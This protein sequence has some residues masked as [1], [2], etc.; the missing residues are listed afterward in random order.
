MKRLVKL[1]THRTGFWRLA[2]RLW[3]KPI[4]AVFAFH[5]VTDHATAPDHLLGYDRGLD[6][7]EFLGQLDAIGSYFSVITLEQYEKI[8]TGRKVPRQHSA[9]LTFDD[10]DSEFLQQILPTLRERNW[11]AVVFT[12][13]NFV[14]GNEFFWHV[15]V[16]HIFL[17]LTIEDRERMRQLSDLPESIST[18]LQQADISTRDGRASLSRKIVTAL[19]MCDDN[20]IL[21][22]VDRLRACCPEMTQPDIHCMNWDEHRELLANSISVQS[23]TSS[24]RRL[25][26]LTRE[27]VS[28][29]L[30]DSKE[31]LQRKLN[32]PVTSICY[33]QGS[34]DSF[35]VQESRKAGYTLGFTTH[36]GTSRYPI[37]QDLRLVIPRVD[38]WSGSP[39]DWHW[40]L[41]RLLTAPAGPSPTADK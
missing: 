13:V 10:A 41:G 12:P 32:H 25:G 17:Y 15:W 16:G 39:E 24:H 5:R 37:E 20:D 36:Y 29:E 4:V 31:E 19:N 38:V 6:G 34:Y 11:P 27:E 33:P 26:K 18:A 1:I 22:I 14:E 35:A 23:H 30:V 3:R 40:S 8:I 21:A 28:Q 9:L 7:Q 2:Y